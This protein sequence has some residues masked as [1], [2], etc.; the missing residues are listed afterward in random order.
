[1]FLFYSR[2]PFSSVTE[3]SLLKNNIVQLCLELTTI[4]QQVL[5]HTF[6]NTCDAHIILRVSVFITLKVM[7]WIEMVHLKWLFDWV[8]QYG[9]A[10]ISG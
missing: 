10:A 5:S 3:Y 9:Y 8:N 4:V 7:V 2:S 6:K 1:M